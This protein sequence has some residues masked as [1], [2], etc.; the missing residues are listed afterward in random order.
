MPPHTHP[1][2]PCAVTLQIKKR[3]MDKAKQEDRQ[4]KEFA[5]MEEAALK[6]Y[7]QDIKRLQMES[8]N[9][10]KLQTNPPLELD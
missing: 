5:A 2:P 9:L 7:E 6:A 4:S 10:Q 8:G 1:P 3:S